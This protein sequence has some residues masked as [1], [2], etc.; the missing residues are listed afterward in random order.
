MTFRT[1]DRQR[2][3][4]TVLRIYREVGWVSEKVHADAARLLSESG[5]GMVAELH[6]E[7]EC[8]VMAHDGVLRHRDTDVPL[9]TV[10]GVTTSRIARKQGLAGRLTAKLLSERAIAG[11]M[12]AILGI[13]EQG[14]YNQLG[15]GNGSYEHWCRVDPAH[16]RIPVKPRIPVR[17]SKDDWQSMHENRLARTRAHG[18][19]SILA[20]DFTHAETAWTDN[21]FGL[22][23]HDDAGT[24]T[25]HVWCEAKGEHG[26]YSAHWMAYRTREQFL[27]LMALIKSLEEQ[28]RSVNLREPPGIQL[29]DF[30]HTPF[31][32]RQTTRR[33]EHENYMSAAAYWQ[34]RMLDIAA[35]M[36]NTHLDGAP[37]RFNLQLTDPVTRYLPESDPWVGVAGTYAVTVGET[38]EA[39]PG[40]DPKLPTLR[41]SV[42]AFTRLWLGVR[43]ATRLAWTDELEG[44]PEL[45]AALDRTFLLPTPQPDWDF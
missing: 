11:D 31:R 3:A 16:L 22:G 25:H 26:P 44:T 15:F 17:L 43:S 5:H 13:F 45:L 28:V 19:C 41:A 7:A 24:L 34:A 4:E 35:C 10:T 32:L 39:V 27:E 6:G 38:S 36:K 40:S 42:N 29:Q 18:A 20:P 2:D 37:L 8:F 14:Y 33:S 21:G 12:V 9:C 1:Y 30:I 23:Y